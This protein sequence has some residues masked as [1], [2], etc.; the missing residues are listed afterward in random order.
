MPCSAVRFCDSALYGGVLSVS[1]VCSHPRGLNGLSC[2]PNCVE[3]VIRELQSGLV[4]CQVT[5]VSKLTFV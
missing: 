4:P 5:M 3:V 2:P 1:T